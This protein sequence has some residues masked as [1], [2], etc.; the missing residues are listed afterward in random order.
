MGFPGGTDG[1]ESTCNAGDLGSIPGLGRSPGGDLAWPPTPVFLPEKFHGP[2]KKKKKRRERESINPYHE[3]WIRS[4]SKWITDLN[5][6]PK[7]IKLI[8]ENIGE[9]IFIILS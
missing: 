9:K 1:K 3:L 8:E 2:K 4:N 6:K 7:T 5:I